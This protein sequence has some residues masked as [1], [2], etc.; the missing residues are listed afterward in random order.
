[1]KPTLLI[2][3]TLGLFLFGSVFLCTYKTPKAAKIAAQNFVKQKA[4]E[5]IKEILGGKKVLRR[6]LLLSKMS[7]KL[8]HTINKD[9]ILQQVEV[10]FSS[11]FESIYLSH[12]KED[13]ERINQITDFKYIDKIKLNKT[14][15]KILATEKYHSISQNLRQDI[16]IFSACNAVLFFFLLLLSFARPKT[17]KALFVPAVLLLLATIIST[18]IYIFGQNWIYV[19][20][21]NNYMGFGYLIYV[22]VI[23][24][25]LCDIAFLEAFFTQIIIEFILNSLQI[26][27]SLLPA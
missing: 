6:L 8:E 27:I 23:F 21:S 24:L 11:L 7:K 13:V 22:A 1:M 18:L 4:K 16:R 2:I 3:A 9:S 26:F 20:L 25:F 14:S 15:L 10:E 17:L 19:L 5:E 12:I